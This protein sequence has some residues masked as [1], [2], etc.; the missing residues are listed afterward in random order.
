[1]Q[2]KNQITGRVSH[3]QDP[4]WGQASRK[5]QRRYCRVNKPRSMFMA[6]LLSFTTFCRP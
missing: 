3:W 6:P 5:G 1:M 4:S 2:Q